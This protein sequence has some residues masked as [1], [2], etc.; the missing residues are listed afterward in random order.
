MFFLFFISLVRP[1]CIIHLL[2]LYNC[3]LLSCSC[4]LLCVN[5]IC[6]YCLWL[7]CMYV[8]CSPILIWNRCASYT[9]WCSTTVG[10][11]SF[12]ICG[13]YVLFINGFIYSILLTRSFS[14]K[15][16][17][18]LKTVVHYTPFGVAQLVRFVPRSILYE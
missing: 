13:V 5:L 8:C 14:L 16:F 11:V 4:Y 10:F 15:I 9:F 1:L 3:R 17:L 18:F 12:Y 7:L 6:S 2:V